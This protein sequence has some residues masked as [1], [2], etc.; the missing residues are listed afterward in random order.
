MFR[1]CAI[2]AAVVAVV[3]PACAALDAAAAVMQFESNGRNIQQQVV[4]LSVST[5]IRS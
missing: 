2:G 5:A 4:P 3:Q 1:A